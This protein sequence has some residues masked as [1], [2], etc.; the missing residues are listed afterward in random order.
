MWYTNFFT[1]LS[2]MISATD[3]TDPEPGEDSRNMQSRLYCTE[4]IRMAEFVYAMICFDL[5]HCAYRHSPRIQCTY[6][7]VVEKHTILEN[8]AMF[9]A[10]TGID[11]MFFEGDLCNMYV[12]GGGISPTSTVYTLKVMDSLVRYKEL[13]EVLV[14]RYIP[15]WMFD[16]YYEVW[17]D[18]TAWAH[19]LETYNETY[20]IEDLGDGEI[21]VSNLFDANEEA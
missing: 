11:S 16:R 2:V 13:Y 10:E 4:D 21:G 7:A 17:R 6:I 8:L 1:R 20:V 19:P 14:C 3:V 12:S 15:E 5:M 18:T 9:L